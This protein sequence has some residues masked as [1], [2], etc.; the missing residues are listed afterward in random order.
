VDSVEDFCRDIHGELV[1]GL[2]LHTG[3][4]DVAEDLAQ[5]TLLTVWRHWRKVRAADNPRAWAWRVALNA[6]TS[7]HR[8]RRL[9]ARH[10]DG[11]V[12]SRPPSDEEAALVVRDAVAALPGR[13]RS[14]LVLRYFV[15]L[16]VAETASV[17]GVAE[18]TVKATAHQA[19][20]RLRPVL[21]TA[22]E[23]TK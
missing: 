19:L 2:S 23:D 17:L 7:H 22:L 1:A 18:G 8:R 21:T 6:A 3:S 10:G 12:T 4:L 5:Q 11:P 15:D 16:S 9:W 14:V 13:Q 20:E